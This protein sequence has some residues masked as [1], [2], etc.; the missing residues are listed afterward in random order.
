MAIP[1]KSLIATLFLVA[2]DITYAN[3]ESVSEGI[4]MKNPWSKN[5]EVLD[6][7][8]D[9]S[10]RNYAFQQVRILN[11]WDLHTMIHPG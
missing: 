7:V 3:A 2:T 9:F 5:G 4:P 1:G 10:D 11:Q 8:S 6:K